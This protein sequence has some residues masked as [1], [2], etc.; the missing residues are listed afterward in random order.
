[1]FCKGYVDLNCTN[2]TTFLIKIVIEALAISK[3]AQ[4]TGNRAT[5]FVIENHL[6][7]FGSIPLVCC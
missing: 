1:M 2:L 3:D 4:E 6:R 5:A 7:P